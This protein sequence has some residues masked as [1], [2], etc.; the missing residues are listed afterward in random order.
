MNTTDT[1]IKLSNVR[2]S[3]PA[4]FTAKKGP[5]ETSKA[6][7]AATFILDKKVN[8]KEIAAIKAGIATLVK[9][10]FKGKMPPKVSLRDGAEKPDLDG[11]GETVMF[12]SARN[13]K[14]QQVVDRDLSPLTEEDGKPFAGCYVNATIR[15]WAQDN[16][17]GKRINASL[18]AVQFYK[19]G[20]PFGEKQVAASEVFDVLPEDESVV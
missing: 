18:G 2:L 3:F 5:E 13:E 6:A 11:Y 20:D 16:K 17:Y 12:V 19:T 9:D 8:A 1:Q 14:R 4:L 10:T 7:F 15:L